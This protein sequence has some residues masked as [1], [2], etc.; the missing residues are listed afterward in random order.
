MKKQLQ[1]KSQSSQ[2]NVSQ[3]NPGYD[4][5]DWIKLHRQNMYDDARSDKTK[6][7]HSG[8]CC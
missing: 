5:Y 1:S 3:W 4:T 8:V 6:R 2:T 7:N